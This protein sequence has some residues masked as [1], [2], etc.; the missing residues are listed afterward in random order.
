MKG[1]LI[2]YVAAYSVFA[3]TAPVELIFPVSVGLAIIS[4]WP[5]KKKGGT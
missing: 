1:W 3:F 5:E 4:F 2:V